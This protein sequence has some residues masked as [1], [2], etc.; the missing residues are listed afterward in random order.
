MVQRCSRMSFKSVSQAY[1]ELQSLASGLLEVMRFSGV[2]SDTDPTEA[3]PDV[4]FQHRQE[5]SLWKHKLDVLRAHNKSQGLPLDGFDLVEVN[6][7][8]LH[9]CLRAT[10]NADEI[11]WDQYLPDFTHIMDVYE[12]VVKCAAKS[13]REK[14]E[15]GSVFSL[16]SD[17]CEMLTFVGSNCR[18]PIARRRAIALLKEWPQKDGIWDTGLIAT[19]CEAKT[20]L[21]EGATLCPDKNCPCIVEDFIC[22]DHR[23][24]SSAVE[25]DDDSHTTI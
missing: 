14:R 22:N 1:L 4:F 3:Q 13:R 2:P 24:A 9:M 19:M 12:D 16:T 7:L 17:L 25:F 5:L 23:I 6:W 11:A 21:E 10:A 8:A 20:Q 15:A 18:N